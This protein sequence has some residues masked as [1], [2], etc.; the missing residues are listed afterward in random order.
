MS[1]IRKS[2]LS[3]LF[4]ATLFFS[5]AFFAGRITARADGAETGL[6]AI[7]GSSFVMEK[8]ASI[9]ADRQ[10]GLRY[11]ATLSKEA[12][13][14]LA[15]KYG[16]DKI[17]FGTFILPEYYVLHY[18]APNA[19]NCFGENP[20]YVWGTDAC[21]E[22]QHIILHNTSKSADFRE[23]DN[24]YVA[25]GYVIGMKGET[26][27][28]LNVTYSGYVYLKAENADG[29]SE[30]LFAEQNDNE[31]SMLLVA[32][33]ALEAP[34][35]EEYHDILNAYLT[36]Y[37][38]YCTEN[39]KSSE[40]NYTVKIVK[41]GAEASSEKLSGELFAEIDKTADFG[42]TDGYVL[43]KAASKLVGRVY[44]DGS[45]TITA[46]YKKKVVLDNPVG[47]ND[48]FY[49]AKETESTAD[50]AN[51]FVKDE[52]YDI[53]VSA[54]SGEISSV[55]IKGVAIKDF[56]VENGVL[57]IPVS[58]I[59]DIECGEG[60]LDAFTAEKCYRADIVVADYV[61]TTAEEFRTVLTDLAVNKSASYITLANDIYN[62]GEVNPLSTKI[63]DYW[64]RGTFD[65]RGYTVSD[66]TI[67]GYG[68]F[69]QIAPLGTVK[70]VAI[71]NANQT[72]N[73]GGAI[74]CGWN[75]GT[76]ENV[77]VQGNAAGHSGLTITCTDSAKVISCIV[78][79]HGTHNE[80]WWYTVGGVIAGS[81]SISAGA[82]VENCYGISDNFAKGLY[83]K[84]GVAVTDGFYATAAELLNAFSGTLPEGFGEFW[85]IKD[86]KLY[87]G[88]G[89][90]LE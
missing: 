2:I 74:L 83:P 18:G 3:L 29:T 54:V 66:M 8:G 81:V 64:F 21:G 65:G 49:F 82:K 10:D 73:S 56:S 12:Y 44:P 37:K 72:Q 57:K 45:L 13:D 75:Y 79:V 11:S 34:D 58:E 22:N 27:R 1:K 5:A 61:I 46:N 69:V 17:S 89:L 14:K 30:Y 90:I 88:N 70:N 23:K 51:A 53:D 67:N 24:N 28:N 36:T 60:V 76:I 80:G 40:F 9:R 62:A 77:Y 4:V 7:A 85:S 42:E 41:D 86:G 55:A 39:D 68:L 26:R 35:N 33:K 47:K 78:N 20:V 87:F 25:E 48:Y 84:D 59:A 32:C 63:D 19:E 16:E 31:R 52:Y 38:E 43:D 6:S 71:V 50:Y 15:E